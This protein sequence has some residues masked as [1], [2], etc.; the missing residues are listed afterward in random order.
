MA[1]D[2]V[3]VRVNRWCPAD[4]HDRAAALAGGDTPAGCRRAAQEGHLAAGPGGLG[5]RRPPGVC[6]ELA[7]RVWKRDS[8]TSNCEEVCSA[9]CSPA[10][11]C[12]PPPCRWA[13][14]WVTSGPV[15]TPSRQRQGSPS[16][17]VVAKTGV[18]LYSI[19]AVRRRGLFAPPAYQ[20]ATHC[21]IIPATAYWQTHPHDKYVGAH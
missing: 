19:E 10:A 12:S 9:V 6:F 20:R 18:C 5:Q 4:G 16:E 13:G 3:R 7:Q 11:A 8:T 21:P 15:H 2:D 17:C 14:R 1:R